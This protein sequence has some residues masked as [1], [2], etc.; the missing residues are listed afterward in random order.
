MKTRFNISFVAGVI[1]IAFMVGLCCAYVGQTYPGSQYSWWPPVQ[2]FILLVAIFIFGIC[3][4]RE[5]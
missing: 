3:S 2:M 5:F 1:Y 4:R